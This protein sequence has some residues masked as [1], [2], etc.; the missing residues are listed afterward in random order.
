MT[1]RFFARSTVVHAVKRLLPPDRQKEKALR[2]YGTKKLSVVPPKF[3]Q[4]NRTHLKP[5]NGGQPSASFPAAAPGRTKRRPAGRLT[6][7]DQPSLRR[8]VHTIFPFPAFSDAHL[9]HR[10][11]KVARGISSPLFIFL[12]KICIFAGNDI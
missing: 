1:E 6:A 10:A 3:T 4:K 7:D 8:T 11:Q 2:P 5:F 12:P 9:Y